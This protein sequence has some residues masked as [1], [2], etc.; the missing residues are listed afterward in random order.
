VRQADGV[1]I[2]VV[3]LQVSFTLGRERILIEVSR[4]Q[5]HAPSQELPSQTPPWHRLY[6]GSNPAAIVLWCVKA[7]QGAGLAVQ[8][9]LV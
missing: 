7:A 5:T 6:L 4:P 1:S 9:T 2:I 8:L 3:M